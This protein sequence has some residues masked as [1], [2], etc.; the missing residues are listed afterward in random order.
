MTGCH[1]SSQSSQS[2][3]LV[4][5]RMAWGSVMSDLPVPPVPVDPLD[6]STVSK[7]MDDNRE[8]YLDALEAVGY[9]VAGLL[10]DDPEWIEFMLQACAEHD[11]EGDLMGWL[12][13]YGL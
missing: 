8:R 11:A 12:G 1:V 6:W 3:C 10:H 2:F 4:L 9:D 13:R 7:S 5:A